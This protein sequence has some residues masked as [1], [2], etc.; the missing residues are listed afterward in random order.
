M[1]FHPGAE[2]QSSWGEHISALNHLNTSLQVKDQTLRWKSFLDKITHVN[3]AW[4]GKYRV[5][6]AG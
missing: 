4:D 2:D 3:R 1:N 5:D 6:N